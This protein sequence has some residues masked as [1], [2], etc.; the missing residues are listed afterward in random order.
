MRTYTIDGKKYEF[1]CARFEHCFG[2]RLRS[3]NRGIPGKSVGK[4]KTKTALQLEIAN[5]VNASDEAVKNWRRTGK[6]KTAPDDTDTVHKLEDFFNVEHGY[7]LKPVMTEKE[8]A[9]MNTTHT[10]RE[11]DSRELEA[12]K[13]L[14]ISILDAIDKT[15]ITYVDFLN[16]PS[17]IPVQRGMSTNRYKLILETRK[18][19]MDL[20]ESVRLPAMEL[21]ND[22]YGPE[23]EEWYAFYATEDFKAYIN[24]DDY[25]AYLKNPNSPHLP[26]E[27]VDN[28]PAYMKSVE[29]PTGLP[30]ELRENYLKQN[31]DFDRAMH[32]QNYANDKAA[33]F[34]RRLD[35]IFADYIKR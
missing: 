9:H 28:Y 12:A 6:G 26:P 13:S 27:L 20:P 2:E 18:T 31:V 5:A 24:S 3:D 11:I 22:I 17:H 1:D 25:Q 19:A 15:D 4:E 7:F 34:Y 33:E 29:L 14:Y 16:N 23:S 10:A 8:N 30:E 21:V 32:Y 35:E